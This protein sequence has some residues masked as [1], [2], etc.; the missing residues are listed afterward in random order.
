V[1]APDIS[2][3]P[4][5][6]APGVVAI[7]RS[8]P[9]DWAESLVGGLV[10]GGIRSI[11]LTTTVPD[12]PW[13]LKR[14]RQAFPRGS[15]Q[16]LEDGIRLGMG[17]LLS[18][19]D[20]R[21]AADVGA[22]FLVSPV[23]NPALMEVARDARLPLWLAGMTPTECWSAHEAGASVV[24]LFPAD[25]LGPGHVRALRAPMPFLQLLPTGGI[26]LEQVPEWRQAGC[27]GVGAGSTLLDPETVR[28]RD[29]RVIRS[30]AAEWVRAWN[31]A[32]ALSAS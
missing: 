20:A 21:R 16:R 3:Q 1:H 2:P 23:M 8:V 29:V 15:S 10:E 22:D 5:G 24:K 11:E 6:A 12:W 27:V 28:G 31:G 13:L 19:E 14:L 18:V 17:T 4:P 26:T 25:A 32:D 30:R 7:L 9:L